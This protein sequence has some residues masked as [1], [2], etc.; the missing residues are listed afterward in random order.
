M[1]LWHR[2]LSLQ[3]TK[4]IYGIFHHILISIFKNNGFCLQYKAEFPLFFKLIKLNSVFP[5]QFK[6]SLKNKR[7]NVYILKQIFNISH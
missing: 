4:Y 7:Q 3:Q 2:A 6:L 1:P 5:R